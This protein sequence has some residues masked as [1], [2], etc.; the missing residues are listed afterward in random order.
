M[1]N[2]TIAGIS[3]KLNQIFG[4]KIYSDEIEQGLL[5]PCFLIVCLTSSQEQELNTLYR[6]EQAFAIHYYPQAAKPT[7][8]IN[9]VV[10]ILN[11]ALEYITVDGNLVRGTKMRHEVADGVLHFFVNYDVRIR[12]VIESDPYMENLTIE[13]RVKTYG[14]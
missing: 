14:D 8:E 3:Q 4:Y 1:L 13:E 7:Q 12:K 2:N 10:D 9:D 11:M 6:R 5:E